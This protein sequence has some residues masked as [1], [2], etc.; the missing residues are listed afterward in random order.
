M[1]VPRLEILKNSL[2][3]LLIFPANIIIC[4]IRRVNGRPTFVASAP[5]QSR[6]F[7]QFLLLRNLVRAPRMSSACFPT[8]C[9]TQIAVHANVL[10]GSDKPFISDPI[11]HRANYL[12][13]RCYRGGL[14]PFREGVQEGQK[15]VHRWIQGRAAPSPLSRSRRGTL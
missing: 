6:R 15:F 14:I 9:W 5:W 11:P 3:S 12:F 13:S 8:R 10:L 7:Q 4:A 1:L 2:R